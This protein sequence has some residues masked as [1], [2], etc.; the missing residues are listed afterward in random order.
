MGAASAGP[1]HSLAGERRK[2]LA[3]PIGPRCFAQD[4]GETL[5]LFPQTL[6]FVYL[7]TWEIHGAHRGELLREG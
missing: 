4:I 3:L 6:T 1:V 5:G 2:L 7:L